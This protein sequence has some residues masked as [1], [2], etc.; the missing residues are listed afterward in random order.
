M[1]IGKFIEYVE[2]NEKVN[3][4]FVRSVLV[5]FISDADKIEEIVDYLANDVLNFNYLKSLLEA[6][7][8]DGKEDFSFEWADQISADRWDWTV[9]PIPENIQPT[10]EDLATWKVTINGHEATRQGTNF[11][12]SFDWR[13]DQTGEIRP[14]EVWFMKDEDAWHIFAEDKSDPSG[15]THIA[16]IAVVKIKGKVTKKE[17]ESEAK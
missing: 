13:G 15:E 9:V 7:A 2:L 6:A 5:D 10:M 16:I 11:I 14:V 17:K 3:P 1:D 12:A 8:D 4:A